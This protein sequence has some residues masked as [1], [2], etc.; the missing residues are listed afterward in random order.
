MKYRVK[1]SVM[2]GWWIYTEGPRGGFRAF[3]HYS[4]ERPALRMA[5]LLNEHDKAGYLS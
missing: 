3:L 4:S 5:A 1:R 2:D